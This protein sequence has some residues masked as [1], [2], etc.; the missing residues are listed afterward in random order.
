MAYATLRR[1]GE[2]FQSEEIRAEG[3]AKACACESVPVSNLDNRAPS[4]NP[5]RSN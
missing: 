1:V 5:Q 2:S 4:P 3:V